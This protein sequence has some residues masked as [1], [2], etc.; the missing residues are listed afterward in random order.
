MGIGP[1]HTR[2]HNV[3]C[4]DEYGARTLEGS[5][6]SFGDNIEHL[7]ADVR[8]WAYIMKRLSQAGR[9]DLLLMLV[10]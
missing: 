5:G 10:R 4:Q 8:P 9:R 3:E 6:C 7:W 2:A 1:W